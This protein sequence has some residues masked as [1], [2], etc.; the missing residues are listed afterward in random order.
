MYGVG[1]IL[2][3]GIYVILVLLSIGVSHNFIKSNKKTSRVGRTPVEIIYNF[4]GL[5]FNFFGDWNSEPSHSTAI[6]NK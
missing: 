6:P 1:R 5:T 2:A 4:V 3:A